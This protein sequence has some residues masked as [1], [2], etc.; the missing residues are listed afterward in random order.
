MEGVGEIDL[1][2]LAA[3]LQ[4][5]TL[6][7]RRRLGQYLP[8]HRSGAGERHHVDGG[9]DVRSSAPSAP[10]STTTLKTPGGRPAASAADPKTKDE[11]G[12]NG[13]GRRITEFPAIKAGTSFWKAMMIAPL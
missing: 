11:S 9:S 10:C 12:V 4:R 7:G 8:S 6:H 1:C 13:L 2:R 3:E 5:H